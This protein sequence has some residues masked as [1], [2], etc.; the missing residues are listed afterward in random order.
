MKSILDL[1][2]SKTDTPIGL[3]SLGISRKAGLE[4]INC[5]NDNIL[6]IEKLF[7]NRNSYQNYKF[8]I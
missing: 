1:F 5:K 4:S 2:F 6:T 3:I 7:A 8:R